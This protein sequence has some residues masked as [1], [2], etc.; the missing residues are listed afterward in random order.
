MNESK[1]KEE[2]NENLVNQAQ[3]LINLEESEGWKIISKRIDLVYAQNVMSLIKVNDESVRGLLKGITLF[4]SEIGSMISQ[5]KAAAEEI[6]K[7]K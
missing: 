6:K 5:G 1:T 3:A 4:K 7:N 2:I